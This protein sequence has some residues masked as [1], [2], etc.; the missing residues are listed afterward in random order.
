MEDRAQERITIPIIGGGW[1]GCAAALTLAKGGYRVALYETAQELGGRARRV[2]RDG[3]P[4]DNGQHVLLGAYAETQQ[5]LA[6]VNAATEV[7]FVQRPL[8]ISP[9]AE[10][11]RDAI[12]LRAWRFPP[13]F[14][15]FAGLMTARG[16]S[17]RDRVA[18]ARWFAALRKR[19]YRVDA[20]MTAAELIAAA[21]ARARERLLMPLCLSALNTPPVRA[22]AQIFANVLRAA[23]DGA[24]GASDM[25]L[26]STDLAGLFPDAIARWLAANGHDIH[27]R[28]EAT[29]VDAVERSLIV[30]SED[31]EIRAPS[32]IVAVAPHQLSRAFGSSVRSDGSVAR[33]IEQVDRLEWEPIVTVYLGYG[34]SFDMPTGLV[35]LDDTP[36]QWIFDRR[37]ILARANAAAPALAALLAVVISGR[38]AHTSLKNDALT[39]AVDAQLR[40]LR[41]GLPRVTWSQVI[42]EKR[43]TY[44]CTPT[45]ARPQ[46]GRL[47]AGIY[48]AGDYTDQTF[49]AT[50]EAAV[51]SGRIAAEQLMHDLHNEC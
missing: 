29:I 25:L 30:R 6:F 9:F 35:Q 47:A 45:A 13:P 26:P 39:Q 20:E 15:L 31:A 7:P 18:T 23:F 3:M 51:R 1:A 33:A 8:E 17:W 42:A 11:Q 5:S 50:L 32:A 16:L 43:A 24:D 38:G 19:A 36:G 4:L 22:S 40:R 14:A 28:A 48:L 2:V 49:P 27:L 21:P 46:P 12:A 34:E 41:P 37:D 10:A 44:S